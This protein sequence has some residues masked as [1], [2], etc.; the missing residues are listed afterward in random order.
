MFLL[1]QQ[2]LLA[3][4]QISGEFFIFQEDSAAAHRARHTISLLERNTPA[5]IAPDL[6]PPNS[7]DINPVDS[8]S[9]WGIMQ[10]SLPDKVQGPGPFETPSDDMWA[11]IQQSLIDTGE[12]LRQ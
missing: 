11:G 4:R 3:I 2:L 6:W 7:P 8:K 9:G 5:F 12:A 1:S 10:H